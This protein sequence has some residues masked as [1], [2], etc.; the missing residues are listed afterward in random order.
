MNSFLNAKNWANH[1]KMQI[2]VIFPNLNT[3]K[4]EETVFRHGYLVVQERCFSWS[5]RTFF[6]QK[7]K[8][9][10]HSKRKTDILQHS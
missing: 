5:V 10:P 8:S 3:Q 2:N 1:V 9:L 4:N 7:L 6:Q